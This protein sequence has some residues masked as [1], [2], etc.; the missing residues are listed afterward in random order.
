V[1]VA[2][3]VASVSTLYLLVGVAKAKPLEAIHLLGWW[4]IKPLEFIKSCSLVLLLYTGPLFEVIFIEKDLRGF[5]GWEQT[6]ATLS[7]W[8]GYRNYIAGPLTEEVIFRS[9]IIPL[10]LIADISASKIVFLTP[11]YFGIAHVHHLYEFKLTHPHTPWLPAIL[12]SIFQFGY[13]TLFGWFASFLYIR[14]GSIYAGV[15][16]HSFCNWGGLPRFWGRPHRRVEYAATPIVVRRKDDG[17]MPRSKAASPEV[18][19]AW[20]VAYY[21]LL[22]VGAYAFYVGFWPL[23]ESTQALATFGSPKKKS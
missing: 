23:T 13:T 22:V 9:V 1:T 14:T 18:S 19:N 2:C 3:I 11:L 21:V 15:L 8:S 10:H 6:V 20:A 17:E 4:P 5:R 7:S 12:R 16:V